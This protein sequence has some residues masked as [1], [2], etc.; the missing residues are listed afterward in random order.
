VAV[1][2]V[3]RD[4]NDA[5]KKLQKESKITEDERTKALADI[6]KDTDKEIAE[7]DRLVKTKEDEIMVV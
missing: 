1:R 3:R 5:I 2:N 4:A 6:Q 7:I